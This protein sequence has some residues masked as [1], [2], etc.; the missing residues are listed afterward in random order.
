MLHFT[1]L[2]DTGESTISS[3]HSSCSA[4]QQFEEEREMFNLTGL[5]ASEWPSW[6]VRPSKFQRGTPLAVDRTDGTSEGESTDDEEDENS[7]SLSLVS[8][9]SDDDED[10]RSLTSSFLESLTLE[11]ILDAPKWTSDLVAVHF[12]TLVSFNAF[13]L[14]AQDLIQQELSAHDYNTFTPFVDFYHKYDTSSC[15]SLV[16]FVKGF[17]DLTEK[18]D[19]LSCVGLSIRLLE[20]MQKH[21]RR[22]GGS[23]AIVSCEE[24]VKDIGSYQIDAPDSLK[25]HVL[26]LTKIVLEKDRVGYV[27]MDPGY[28]VTRPVVIMKDEQYPHTGNFIVSASERKQEEYSYV[29]QDERF[30]SWTVK[31]TRPGS[32]SVECTNLIYTNKAFDKVAVTKKRSLLYHMKSYVVRSNKGP[33]AGIF[34]FLRSNCINFFYPG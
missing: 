25:E 27:L 16:D 29:V 14:R 8:W 17:N 6:L 10:D 13:L 19:G 31:E 23:L 33:V 2:K 24:A 28:H 34:A 9:T 21:E 3:E 7:S 18:E 22:L 4:V 15:K 1:E 5:F 26:L 12:D 32:K 30:L 11:G 20:K